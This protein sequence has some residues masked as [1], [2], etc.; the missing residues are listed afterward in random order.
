M[1][2]D[3]DREILELERDIR[4]IYDEIYEWQRK[5]RGVQGASTHPRDHPKRPQQER[6]MNRR[7]QLIYGSDGN[8]RDDLRHLLDG[9][10]L[11]VSLLDDTPTQGELL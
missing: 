5:R 2:T 7:R 11:D 9:K 6:L 3:E 8:F 4:A 10:S 1:L